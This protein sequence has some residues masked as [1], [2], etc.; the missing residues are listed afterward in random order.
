M[1]GKCCRVRL[2]PVPAA[3]ALPPPSPGPIATA[4]EIAYETGSHRGA[5]WCDE[6]NLRT[7]EIP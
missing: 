5:R 3:R 1:N 2:R 7:V 4:A 6:R